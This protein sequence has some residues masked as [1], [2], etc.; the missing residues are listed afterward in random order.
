MTTARQRIVGGILGLALGDALGAP[1]EFRRAHDDPVADTGVRAA[2]DGPPAGFLDRRHGDGSQPVDQPDRHRRHAR[3]RRR[4]AAT[5]R[6]VGELAARRRQPDPRRAARTSAGHAGRRQGGLRPSR[7]RGERRQRQRDVLRAARARVREPGRRSARGRARAQR[8]HPLGRTLQDGLRRGDAGRRRARP[9]RRPG[10][11]GPR[12]V[13]ARSPTAKVGRNSTTSPAPRASSDRSTVPTRGSR[14][15]PR[16][17]R[18]AWR[19]RREPFEEGLREVVALGGDTDTNASVAGALLGALHGVDALPPD[20]LD[21]LVEAT[22]IREE[23]E[24]LAGLVA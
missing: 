14:S 5:P 12:G 20:W 6:V 13:G 19:G 23:A 10:V 15:S 21:R 7:S 9:R 1:F 11:G 24:A 8:H 2:V 3:H 17:S 22:A 4:P 18:S 16:G